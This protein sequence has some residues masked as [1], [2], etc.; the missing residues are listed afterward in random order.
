MLDDLKLRHPDL[1]GEIWVCPTVQTIIFSY[2]QVGF[3]SKESG[4]ILLGYRRGPHIE[5]A[6]LSI[7]MAIDVRRRYRFERKD[8]G[9]QLLSDA[10]WE[11]SGGTMHYLGEW[12]THPEVNPMPSPL[13]RC[14][15][16]KLK[17]Y[18]ADPLVF[19]IAGTE[20]W[21][22]EFGSRVWKVPSPLLGRG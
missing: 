15:W 14:E 16:G 10:R 17:N 6:D 21:H 9:H 13:D 22:F 11:T 2:R 3:F 12:H 19:L 20:K 4:G 18:Y 5:I 1:P 7:P 8:P